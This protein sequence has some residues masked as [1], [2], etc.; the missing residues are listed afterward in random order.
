M[1]RA[2]RIFGAAE[3]VS[4]LLLLGVAM[5]LK[6][7]MGMP[8]AVKCVGAAHGILFLVYLGAALGLAIAGKWPVTRLLLAWAAALFPFGPFAFDAWVLRAARIRGDAWKAALVLALSLL[9]GAGFSVMM[10]PPSDTLPAS[11]A[12]PGT[13]VLLPREGAIVFGEGVAADWDGNVYFNEMSPN[14]RTMRVAA[15]RDS[16]KVWRRAGDAPNGLWLDSR[17]R[18]VVCQQRAIIRVSTD[19]AFDGRTDT[20]YANPSGRD[21]NDVTG[22]LRDNLYFTDF[23][24]GSVFYRDAETGETKEVLTGRPRPNGIEWDE[25]RKVVYVC[26]NASGKVAAYDVGVDH[27]LTGRRDFASVP[28]ADGITLDSAGNVY[29]VCFGA[30]VMVF[31]PAGA[32]LGEIPLA[33]SQ[34]TNLAFGGGDFRTLFLITDRGLHK[35]P[36]RVKGYK[37]GRPATPA[38]GS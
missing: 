37:S 24:G 19:A 30:T 20:L 22:D 7:L 29:A 3:A 6:Y 5:P 36:M 4:F 2:F 10:A 8:W 21:F 25:E 23:A 34:L 13:P 33:G 35:L 16:A 38:S 14:N 31:S 18:L 9:L 17:N 27:A 26:E 1:L 15:G 28:R 11:L 12:A 32:P